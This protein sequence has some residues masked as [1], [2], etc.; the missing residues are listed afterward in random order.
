MG[1]QRNGQRLVP[2]KLRKSKP[3][4]T[5][6]MKWR[7]SFSPSRMS[8]IKL[9]VCLSRPAAAALSRHG[10]PTGGQLPAVWPTHLLRQA[11]FQSCVFYKPA[12]TGPCGQVRTRQRRGARRAPHYHQLHFPVRS[13]PA[14]TTSTPPHPSCCPTATGQP[15][16]RRAHPPAVP[17]ISSAAID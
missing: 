14:P 16:L 6:N 17:T 15:E 7:T 2:G 11:Y 3:A 13:H 4:H 12:P 8:L 5:T 9:F 1:T 10:R